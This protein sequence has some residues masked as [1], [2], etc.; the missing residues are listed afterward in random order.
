M[1]RR[2]R[3]YCGGVRVHLHVPRLAALREAGE[4]V[5]PA[6]MH[7]LSVAVGIVDAVLA[8]AEAR[9]LGL[10]SSVYLRLG[11]S[12]G[13]DRDALLFS[14]PIACQDTP[15]AGAQLHI[16]DVA[17]VVACASCGAES[18]AASFDRLQCPRCG[19]FATRIVQGREIELRAFE[20]TEIGEVHT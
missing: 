5:T 17:L 18:E 3:R 10:V 11:I 8:E 6:T 7:E 13:V 2:D 16:D 9:G 19:D 20:A 14:F 12:S 1:D 15:L 4:D